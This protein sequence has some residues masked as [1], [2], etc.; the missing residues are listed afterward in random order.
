MRDP[1]A[2][3][4]NLQA[5]ISGYDFFAALRLIECAYCDKPRI[6]QSR[7]PQDD[8]VRFGQTPSLAF[9][10]TLL[11][12][13]TPGV[14]GA[15]PR[16]DVNFFGLL[17]ANGPMPVHLTEYA[18]DRLRN[19]S[20][21]TLVRF[22][23]MFHHRMISL[24]Y[25]AWAS[26]QPVV[27]F[28]RSEDD[29]FADYVASLIGIGMKSLRQRDAAPDFAKLHYAGHLSSQAR[30][31]EGLGAM[32]GEYFKVPVVIQQFVGHW[33]TLSPDSR[34]RLISGHKAEVLGT[35]TVL[36][37]KVWN[38]QHKFRIIMGPLTLDEYTRMLPGSA[39]FTRLT[40]LVRNYVG[41][42]FDWD[43]NLI[44]KKEEIPAFKM[45]KQAK[46]GWLTWL[47]SQ[48]PKTD[49]KQL[50]LNPNQQPISQ[51]HTAMQG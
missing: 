14:D 27:S 8:A 17:G 25:R 30:N 50:L 40:A 18:R 22:L 20:D 26:A 43:V 16:L 49:D 29:R 47:S 11:A 36:G 48:P 38:S 23:D 32:L 24:F 10:H 33:M 19:S 5:E 45:G 7:Q 44:L 39:S 6:G 21:P 31:A 3:L 13:L 42:A 28:D 34:C 35:T 46:L 9:E 15:A 12:A 37:G 51:P 4:S 2:T 1:V 41:I